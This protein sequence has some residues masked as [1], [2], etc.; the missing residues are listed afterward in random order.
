MDVKVSPIYGSVLEQ[1][2][3]EV[4]REAFLAVP[5]RFKEKSTLLNIDRDTISKHCMLIGGTGCGKS[6]VFYHLIEQ[7][8]KE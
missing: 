2:P 6:N 3:M 1:N 4:S 5:G 7:I 8:K